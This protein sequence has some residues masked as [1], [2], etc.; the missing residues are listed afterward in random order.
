MYILYNIYS[1][2]HQHIVKYIL[3]NILY[4]VY[5]YTI[6]SIVI[7]IY[8]NEYVISIYNY[9]TNNPTAE[10]RKNVRASR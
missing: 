1:I 10:K 7:S 6:Y 3:Y 9:T 5:L 2:V 8:N 4:I